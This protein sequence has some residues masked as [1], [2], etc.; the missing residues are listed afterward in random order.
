M[1]SADVLDRIKHV[2]EETLP[3]GSSLMLYGSRARGEAHEQSDWDLLILLDKHRL[4]FHDYDITYPF[5]MLGYDI[6][7]DIS[8]HIYTKEQWASWSFLPYYKNVER[9]KIVLI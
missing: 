9:D 2:G 4:T 7:E 8:P 5:R 6:G 3:K 1:D